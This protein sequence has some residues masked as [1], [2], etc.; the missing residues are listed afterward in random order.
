MIG[1]NIMVAPCIFKGDDTVNVYFPFGKKLL[2]YY[3]I[4]I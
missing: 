1:K 3:Y 2:I 4:L